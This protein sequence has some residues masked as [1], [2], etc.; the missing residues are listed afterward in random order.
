[1]IQAVACGHSL[2][3]VHE[4]NFPDI[5]TG[6]IASNNTDGA[7]PFDTTPAVFDN[8][9]VIEYLNNTGLRGGPLVVGF[10]TT[11]NSDLRIFGSDGNVTIQGLAA[12]DSFRDKCFA[13]FER[14]MDTVSINLCHL[15]IASIFMQKRHMA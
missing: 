4:V 12:P 3:S 2:G 6:A 13:I 5:V 8:A 11:T 9:N 1:M 14:M 15:F 10:N 7:S